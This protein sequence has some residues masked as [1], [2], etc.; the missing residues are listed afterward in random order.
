M[1]LS[2][3]RYYADVPSPRQAEGRASRP[4]ESGLSSTSR[5]RDQQRTEAWLAEWVYGVADRTEYV[6]KLG[7]ETLERLKPTPALADTIDY[8]NYT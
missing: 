2:V 8:G 7:A 6:R 5:S 3:R 4:A 1:A